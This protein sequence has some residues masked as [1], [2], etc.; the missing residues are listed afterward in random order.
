MSYLGNLSRLWKD[1]VFI[2]SCI[3]PNYRRT[4]I[5]R[6][7]G[8]LQMTGGT[9]RS[10]THVE[11]EQREGGLW[12][13]SLQQLKYMPCVPASRRHF[14]LSPKSYLERTRLPFGDSDSVHCLEMDF[15]STWCLL[16]S[17]TKHQANRSWGTFHRR[18]R[19]PCSARGACIDTGSGRPGVSRMGYGP[20]RHCQEKWSNLNKVCWLVHGVIITT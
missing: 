5:R 12:L 13:H 9:Y 1:V 7:T 6:E 15:L 14:S 3:H 4:E 8:R 2:P 16:T 11:G 10:H 17:L 20:H 19:K 18:G